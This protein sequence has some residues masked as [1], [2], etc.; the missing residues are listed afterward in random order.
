MIDVNIFED[1][2][3][4]RNNY[5]TSSKIIGLVKK[6]IIE[7]W[8][9]ANSIGILYFL[10]RKF[11]SEVETRNK[12]KELLEGFVII[13]LRNN[14]INKSFIEGSTDFE[15][16]LQIESAVQFNLDSIITRNKK[17]FNNSRIPVYTPEEFLEMISPSFQSPAV[18]VSKVPFLDLKT[19]L[20]DVYNNIDDEITNIISN[21]S[22]VLGKAVNDFEYSFA[23]AHNAK[24]CYCVSNGTAGNHMV[25][26]ALGIGSGDEVIVPNNTFIATAWGATLCGATP[27][28]VDC[29]PD[30]YNIDPEKIVAAITPKTKAIVAVHLYGQPADMDGI[31]EK[32]KSK[33]FK[34]TVNGVFV[35]T[36]TG[37]TIYLVED[38]AQAHISQYNG[39]P[40]GSLGLAS[41]FSF[42]PG[43]NLGAFGEGGAVLTD[44]EELAKKFKMIRDHGA[45]QKYIHHIYGHNY[46]MEA[47]QGAVLGVKLKHLEVWTNG[48]RRVA[49]KYCELLSDV[50]QIK[51]PGEMD[52]SKHVYHLFVIQ[53][54]QSISQST[55]HSSRSQ[56]R[57]ELQKY[58]GENGIS[59]GLHYPVPLHMQPCFKHLGYKKGDFPVSE[60]LAEQG[61][62][63]P[64]FAELTD[65]QIEY[66]CAKIKEFFRS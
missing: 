35:H 6:N 63:L 21:T 59:T 3:S 64:M 55:N 50:E 37:Q 44:D 65:D 29:H 7:G 16:N 34:E 66:T 45:E 51:L 43:K 19:Q 13:P 20:K 25:L 14:I 30:S 57:D 60:E 58:L 22:F 27:V 61:L 49:A 24:Y 40:V 11:L 5:L 8:L 26:W 62:S 2:L 48:R 56:M 9:S 52:Y 23:Q 46:R 53:V 39:K 12:I 54:K 31:K 36:V 33:K 4:K 17:D 15:D 18:P 32:V 42:Y 47:I 41:S 10:R 1:F 38:C 28:F